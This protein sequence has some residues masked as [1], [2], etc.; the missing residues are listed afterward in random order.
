MDDSRFI[1][2]DDYYDMGSEWLKQGVLDKAELYL[3]KVIDLNPKFIYA[4]IDLAFLYAKNKNYN[5]AINSLRKAVKQDP[6]FDRLYYL[7]SKYAYKDRDYKRSLKSIEKAIEI[8]PSRLYLKGKAI[9]ENKYHG[10][11]R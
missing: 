9:I 10:G 4:Y 8:N 2:A 7:I 1:E 6:E 3:R 5:D 11:K